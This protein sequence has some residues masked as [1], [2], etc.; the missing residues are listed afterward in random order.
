MT[1]QSGLPVV[2]SGKLKAIGVASLQ[3]DALLPDLP[4]FHAKGMAVVR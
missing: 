4:T 2:K 1:F 3:R